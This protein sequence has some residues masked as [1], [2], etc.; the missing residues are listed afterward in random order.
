MFEKLKNVFGCK[1]A[2]CSCDIKITDEIKYIGV[3]DHDIDLFEGQFCVPLGM[4]YNSYL[5]DDEK[6]CVLDTVDGR[7]LDVWL[8]NIDKKLNGTEPDFLVIHHMESD[9][10]SCIMD[11]MTK[12]KN[13]KIVSNQKAFLMMKNFFGT[14]FAERNIVVNEGDELVL[15]KSTLAFIAAPMVHWP[16]VMVSYEK[17]SKTLFS[18][19]GF[20]KF[21][22]LDVIDPEGWDCEARRYYFGIVGKYGANVQALLKKA[23]ALD[24]NRICS[25]HGP[26]LD[27][28]LAH[29]IDKYDIWSSYR[30]ETKGVFIVYTSV[31]GHT[32]E[33]A[34][35]LEKKLKEKINDVVCV[36]LAR[37][38]K[39]E[40]VEKAFQYSHTILATTTYNAGI[41]PCMHE[42]I[43]ALTERGYKNRKLGLIENG[44]WAPN[45][46]RVI[47]GLFEKSQGLEFLENSVS[48]IS[49]Q[50]NDT[51]L[52]LDNLANE[53]I[54]DFIK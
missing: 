25:L 8:R 15:G 18:A 2:N 44:S 19:D 43:L 41:F 3:N 38:D 23:S 28:N 48:I 36:D 27:S 40:A 37:Y 17:E 5:I 21:G 32:K 26:I 24:I 53:I 42:F 39:H 13:A 51:K 14:D 49:S 20:G 22:A 7:F 31:Y 12:Y 9:H 50:N 35:S 4:S 10:S 33:V 1:K 46:I 11:F 29:Y 45:A 30:P 6:K 47:K 34:L 52:Q 54:K 16:E